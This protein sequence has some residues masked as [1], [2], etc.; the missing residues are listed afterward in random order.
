MNKIKIPMMFDIVEMDVEVYPHLTPEGRVIEGLTMVKM[1]YH[2]Y[3]M[4]TNIG[5]LADVLNASLK[6][7]ESL[8]NNYA[9][10]LMS[11]IANDERKLT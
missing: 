2:G 4:M 11:K 1:S 3:E 5:T 7:L 8:H 10:K 6:S 9:I